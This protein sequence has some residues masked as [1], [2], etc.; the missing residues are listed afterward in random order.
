M[1]N[2]NKIHAIIFDMDGTVLASEGLFSLAEQKLLQDYGVLVDINDL[3]IF[4]GMSE[5]EFYPQFIAKFKINDNP[6]AIKVKLKNYLFHIMESH[7]KYITGFESFYKSII[8]GYNIKTSL[9]TNT[10]IDIVNKV[11]QYI[12]IN[13]YFSNIITSNDVSESKPSPIPYTKAMRDLNVNPENTIIIEDSKSGLKSA[14]ASGAH[15]IAITSTLPT[16]DIYA[17]D[18]KIDIFDNYNAISNFLEKRL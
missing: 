5:Q 8:I 10:S 9:V 16:S 18:K 14:T 12:N 3:S 15:T 7:L 17:I 2:T 6:N 1:Y 13:D 11:R 4:R